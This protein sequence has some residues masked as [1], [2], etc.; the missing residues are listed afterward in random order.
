[1]DGST[2]MQGLSRRDRPQKGATSADHP[3]AVQRRSCRETSS[4]SG[5]RPVRRPD[6][7]GGG[8]S[9]GA[10]EGRYQTARGVIL[11]VAANDADDPADLVD[12][13]ELVDLETVHDRERM[14]EGVVRP[15]H[16][17]AA[18]HQA[19]DRDR[20]EPVAVMPAGARGATLEETDHALV[21]DDGNGVEAGDL[22]PGEGRVGAVAPGDR[23]GTGAHA[24]AD[25]HGS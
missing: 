22:H 15:A 12:D 19:R 4:P 10:V 17:D 8:G 18:P 5:T 1:M 16:E 25:A 13:R 20:A 9:V 3:V 23:H 14:L 7:G 2:Y 21:V 6:A 24:V 11:S